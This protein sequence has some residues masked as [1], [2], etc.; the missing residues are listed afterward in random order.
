M[1]STRYRTL[2]L[3]ALALSSCEGAPDT[4]EKVTVNL[5]GGDVHDVIQSAAPPERQT[6]FIVFGDCNGPLGCTGCSAS[7]IARDTVLFARHCTCQAEAD[8]LR[9]RDFTFHLLGP[10]T[11]PRD[12][13]SGGHGIKGSSYTFFARDG[14]CQA[15]RD[16]DS[17]SEADL[18]L[19]FL[20]R[21][22]SP[23]ELPE[24]LP[25]YTG[26]DFIDRVFNSK[27]VL[28]QSF[29]MQPVQAVMADAHQKLKR[30]VGDRELHRDCGT[31]GLGRC[32]S[33]T[34]DA[35]DDMFNEGD[36]GG[37][38]SFME[39]GVSPVE[40]G[41][42]SGSDPSHLFGIISP[43]SRWC[44]TWDDHFG[45]GKFINSQVMDADGDGVRDFRDNCNPLRCPGDPARCA[46]P[47][48]DD[49]DNDGIGDACDNCP[50]KR[51]ADQL[52][53][54][55]DGVGDVCD[56]CPHKAAPS[57]AVGALDRDGDGVGDACDTCLLT[58]N[59]Y[60]ICETDADCAPSTCLKQDR[61]VGGHCADQIDD[62]DGDGRG[63]VCDSC[64]GVANRDFQSNSNAVAEGREQAEPRGD[65]CDDSPVFSSRA[66]VVDRD[67]R[68]DPKRT[69]AFTSYAAVGN[70][71]GASAS[72]ASA[73]VGFRHCNCHSVDQNRDLPMD[74]CLR[75]L[76]IPSPDAFDA[77]G[78]AWRKVTT[79]VKTGLDGLADAPPPAGTLDLQ[80]NPTY[81][82]EA[83]TCTDRFAHSLQST[84]EQITGACRPGRPHTLFWSQ[85]DDIAA[86]RVP[87][88][89]P[90][91]SSEQ[92][93]AGVFWTHARVAGNAFAGPRD[94]ASAGK[95]RDS[96]DYVVT[97][98]VSPFFEL[99]HITLPR[100]LPPLT[101]L[102]RTS[103]QCVE[104]FRPA[105]RLDPAI[106]QSRLSTLQALAAPGLFPA[107]LLSTAS[108]A[109]TEANAD[110][111][112]DA[113]S[114]AARALLGNEARFWL[115]PV[116]PALRETTATATLRHGAGILQAVSIGRDFRQDDPDPV[117]VLAGA[118]GR[119]DTVKVPTPCDNNCGSPR[120]CVAGQCVQP[121]PLDLPVFNHQCPTGTFGRINDGGACGCVV[122]EPL[123]STANDPGNSGLAGVVGGTFADGQGVF[124]PSDRTGVRSLLSATER[125]VYLVGGRRP[126]GPT[127]EIWRYSLDTRAWSHMFA[128][129][130][131]DAPELGQVRLGDVL[132]LAYDVSHTRLL[133]VDKVDFDVSPLIADA[134]KLLAKRGAKKHKQGGPKNVEKEL[135][136]VL[137]KLSDG[138]P[139]ALTAVEALGAKIKAQILEGTA[140]EL[141]NLEKALKKKHLDKLSFARFSIFDTRAGTSFVAKAVPFSSTFDKLGA[142]ARPDGSFVLVGTH[143]NASE[144]QAFQ[145]GI[146]G[147]GQV[148]TRGIAKGSG[149]VLQDPFLSEVGLVLPVQDQASLLQLVELPATLFASSTKIQKL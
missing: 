104:L 42:A 81:T 22:I 117:Q 27:P 100:Q 111:A 4:A 91:G 126:D 94:Q 122:P 55:H 142:A 145:L 99:G 97:P 73:P 98:L 89:T 76:C 118:D 79:A 46:N 119:L 30:T 34:I 59:P 129:N 125:A 25:V 58:P 8:G 47:N 106:F 84:G 14:F 15:D 77:P 133:V 139:D 107:K 102:C 110:P 29:F 2:G 127:G 92:R 10:G 64:P 69:T 137:K 20:E 68:Y 85:A 9:A 12:I 23:D 114:P 75:S 148:E 128:L 65:T 138:A 37:P 36:S 132:A 105:F 146:A 80:F 143:W 67:V 140:K 19:L 108:V 61:N 18:A 1:T 51:N 50:L 141:A 72:F 147:P 33:V 16:D 93:T 7:V 103:P 21:E 48:Q 43:V 62:P 116:E 54:D 135:N 35:K 82:N 28:G 41:V 87:S 66:V 120:L 24:V 3:A 32:G 149:K 11:P 123:A 40:W 17:L 60:K 124:A 63:A 86:G 130:P 78:S 71:T 49:S 45:N 88:F 39:F 52:D 136:D 96:Y 83:V 26:A 109:S 121:C 101:A 90:P 70:T 38:L 56:P 113:I 95:L 31:F 57:P 53:S 13:G 44:P 115:S 112:F 74:E 134:K 6:G 131:A 144:W 5:H